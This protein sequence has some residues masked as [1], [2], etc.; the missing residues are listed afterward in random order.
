MSCSQLT[1]LWLF[2]IRVEGWTTLAF[3]SSF[4]LV[5][6]F[7]ICEEVRKEYKN[8]Q[9]NEKLVVEPSMDFRKWIFLQQVN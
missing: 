4:L 1:I 5:S 8:P 6:H 7:P 3:N 2:Q 9:T